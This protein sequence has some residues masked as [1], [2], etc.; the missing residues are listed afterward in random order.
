LTAT[1]PGNVIHS[2]VARPLPRSHSGCRYTVSIIDENS[3]YVTVFVMKRKSD[4]LG[5]FKSFLREFERR[6]EAKIKAV[7]SDNGGEYTL[8]AKF[9]T[10]RGIA[11][12]RSSP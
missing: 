4:V 3:R 2:D 7:H 11:V 6:Q 8:V 12:H 5:C 9:A 1:K 10:G